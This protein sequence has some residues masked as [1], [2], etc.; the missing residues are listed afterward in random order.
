MDGSENTF[1][2]DI[3]DASSRP[4]NFQPEGY[5]VVISDRAGRREGLRS[6]DLAHRSVARRGD[7]L[8]MNDGELA[9]DWGRR[10]RR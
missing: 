6:V 1:P 4:W 10:H 2:M 8:A 9:H 3:T 5:L 7:W